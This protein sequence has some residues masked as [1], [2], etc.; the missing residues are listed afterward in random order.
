MTTNAKTYFEMAKERE[1]ELEMDAMS[2]DGHSALEL[3][4]KRLASRGPQHPA[5]PASPPPLTA[6]ALK[7]ALSRRKQGFESPR[8]R[9]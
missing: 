9:E 7:V 8:E 1:Q 3:E 2:A 6:D 5:Q 4:A